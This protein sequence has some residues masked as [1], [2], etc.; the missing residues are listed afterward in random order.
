[1]TNWGR[2]YIIWDMKKL[3]IRFFEHHD[4]IP[5]NSY[6]VLDGAVKGSGLDEAI[7]GCRMDIYDWMIR[8][9]EGKVDF[10]WL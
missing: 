4:G 1:M 6:V 2:W 3:Y 8:Y 10:V 5:W 7:A 9:P